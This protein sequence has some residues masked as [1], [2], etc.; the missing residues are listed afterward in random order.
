[1]SL[2][3]ALERAA[4]A[5]AGDADQIRPANG[6]PVQLLDVLDADAAVRV[7]GWLLSND[8]D[9]ADELASSWSEEPKGIAPLQQVNESDLPKPG[10]WEIRLRCKPDLH[11]PDNSYSAVVQLEC[12][13]ASGKILEQFPI[14]D[15]FGTSDWQDA[16]KLL[17]LPKGTTWGQIYGVAVLCGVGFTMSLF[18]GGLARDKHPK[19]G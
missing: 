18:V 5:L 9:A 10:R 12:L 13:D 3:E 1:M 15:V 8:A 19:Q 17:E 14:A 4:S 7:L 11:S 16:R 6:D 2:P